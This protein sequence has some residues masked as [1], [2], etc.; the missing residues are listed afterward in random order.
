MIGWRGNAVEIVLVV[1][2]VCALAVAAW[3]ARRA[4][5]AADALRKAS[6]ANAGLDQQLAALQER[7][8]RLSRYQTILD[9]EATAIALRT[10]AKALASQVRTQADTAA[11]QVVAAARREA[12]HLV[13]E[14]QA[15]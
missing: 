13:T 5:T 14:A 7:V 10:E 15:A 12:D 1:L 11:A 2:L 9:A 8:Q 3:F 6:A 4:A